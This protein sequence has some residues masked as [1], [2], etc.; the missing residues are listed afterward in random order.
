MVMLH[1]WVSG[2]EPSAAAQ[3]GVWFSLYEEVKFTSREVVYV[4]VT[5]WC[6]PKPSWDSAN[7]NFYGSVY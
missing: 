5:T 6:P 1:V 4:K 2:D 3:V 7:A